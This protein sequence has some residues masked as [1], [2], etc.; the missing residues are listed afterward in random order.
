MLHSRIAY[1][2]QERLFAPR[3]E[4]LRPDVMAETRKPP[5]APPI[6]AA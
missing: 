2:K 5:S 3:S 6:S 1:P 4:T